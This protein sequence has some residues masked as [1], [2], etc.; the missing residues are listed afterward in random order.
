MWTYLRAMVALILFRWW[1]SPL[2]APYSAGA[3]S[4][5]SQHAVTQGW[6]L[7]GAPSALSTGRKLN[8]KIFY[9]QF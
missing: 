4:F 1:G 7:A 5:L 8:L 2:K 6:L 9:Q 3:V